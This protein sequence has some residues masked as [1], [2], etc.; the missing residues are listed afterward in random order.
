VIDFAWSC[1]LWVMES[2]REARADAILPPSFLV[3]QGANVVL[4]R[5]APASG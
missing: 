5:R 4:R 3:A 2:A 1:A